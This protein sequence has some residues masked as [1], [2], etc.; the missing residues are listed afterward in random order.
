MLS[1]RI[2]YILCARSLWR[3]KLQY[4]YRNFS[5]CPCVPLFQRNY[6]SSMSKTTSPKRFQVSGISCAAC[7]QSIEKHMATH[8]AVETCRVNL[9]DESMTLTFQNT[10]MEAEEIDTFLHKAGYGLAQP[11]EN[12]TENS[13]KNKMKSLEI[14]IVL[15]LAFLSFGFHFFN[16][17]YSSWITF[18]LSIP[19]VL[20]SG[21]GF[22]RRGLR[23]LWRWSPGMD[24][25][26]TMGTGIAYLYS[27]GVLFLNF[28]GHTHFDAAVMVIALVRLGKIIEDKA[29]RETRA[30]LESLL[31]LY[32]QEVKVIRNGE[33][34]VLK[35]EEIQVG[36]KI[37]IAPGDRI[38]ADGFVK[39]GKAEL[40]EQ[41][42]TGESQPILKTKKEKVR[43]GT[44]CLNGNILMIAE[45]TGEETALARIIKT[46]QEA[47]SSRPQMQRLADHVSGIF[48]PVVLLLATL[49]F[50]FWY[51]ETNDIH[52]ALL[53]AVSVLVVACPCAMG[54]A[55]PTAL[56]AAL[57]RATQEQILVKDAI[58]LENTSKIT[59]IV[60]DKTGTLTQGKPHVKST[61]LFEAVP[62]A[63]ELYGIVA[64]AESESNHPLAQAL[65]AYAQEKE[66]IVPAE[67]PEDIR[68][69]T[70]LGMRFTHEGEEWLLGNA[71]LLAQEGVPVSKAYEA[72]ASS[73]VFLVK[74]KVLLLVFYLEDTLR[75]EATS[76]IEELKRLN[77][78]VH[79]A[80]GDQKKYTERVAQELEI[81]NFKGEM[82]P[83]DKLAYLKD[84]Q[85]ED[86]QVLFVGDGINDAPALAQANVGVAMGSGTEV[87]LETAA[88]ALMGEKISQIPKI[89][90][91]AKHTRR[92][93]LQNLGWAFGY[94][95]LM[96]PLAAGAFHA[97]GWHLSPALAGGAM[98]LSSVS[99]VL[100]SLRLR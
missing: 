60:F 3:H 66:A 31:K 95:I 22:Y 1:L 79:L 52:R 17:Q 48:V 83:E 90:Q 54:L 53:F 77:L 82:L 9:A 11:E 42:L 6:K 4:N 8:E 99:V 2:A 49:T 30:A 61:F 69:F 85:A 75:P 10:E 37:E 84:L 5:F 91:L 70:G 68:H 76:L 33:R 45:A 96:I 65:V 55:T 98:A 32:P 72:Q 51:M 41:M 59:D 14:Y 19:V 26:I 34:V 36:D 78:Q 50:G 40:D 16:F 100:N 81:A 46:V 12:S 25:L 7:V 28:P 47:Q 80:S 67:K 58:Q 29:K 71:R 62:N 23:Q 18:L 38:P 87:A 15:S 39:K 94:N 35:L 93:I 56:S 92:I 73:E 44:V 63:P 24:A 74:N 86:K 43:A 20:W 97:W 57:G 64:A 13:K 89:I 27:L 21:L 88:I